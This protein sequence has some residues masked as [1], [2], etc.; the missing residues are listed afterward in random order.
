MRS[1]ELPVT[2]QCQSA[3][4]ANPPGD[5]ASALAWRHADL[6]QQHHDLDYMICALSEQATYDELLVARLKKRKLHLK[7]EIARVASALC[8]TGDAPGHP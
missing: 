5:A 8:A 3:S 4:I 1:Q 2:G 7:D 6:T